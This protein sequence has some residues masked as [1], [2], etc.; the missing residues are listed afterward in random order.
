MCNEALTRL[1][2]SAD[3]KAQFLTLYLFHFL[4]FTPSQIFLY[5]KDERALPGARQR[6]NI[7][8]ASIKYLISHYPPHNFFSLSFSGFKELNHI[9]IQ[10]IIRPSTDL[11]LKWI[12]PKRRNSLLIVEITWIPRT[13]R[14]LSVA[15]WRRVV[16]QHVPL[17]HNF[18]Q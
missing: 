13:W 12:M 5:Q 1:L 9:A 2:S 10:W 18:T 7:F 15:M 17:R 16:W 11:F 14:A 8:L 3:N 4:R 6:R